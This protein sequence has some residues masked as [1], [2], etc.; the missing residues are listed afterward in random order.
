MSTDAITIFLGIKIVIHHIFLQT[1]ISH[2]DK[3][4][5]FIIKNTAKL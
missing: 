1:Q 5:V 3:N 4:S 2:I